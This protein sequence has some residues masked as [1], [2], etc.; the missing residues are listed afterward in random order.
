MN[1]NAKI[2][3]K[4]LKHA[5]K[6][7]TMIPFQVAVSTSLV[8]CRASFYHGKCSPSTILQYHIRC[9]RTCHWSQTL[10]VHLQCQSEAAATHHA[11]K[12][13]QAHRPHQDC[14]HQRILFLS[15]GPS[16]SHSGYPLNSIIIFKKTQLT[17]IFVT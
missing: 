13:V 1:A 10:S 9:L 15:R 7:R 17:I 6:L 8:P 16:I 14:Y 5:S 12:T 2:I 11:G 4:K 3:K